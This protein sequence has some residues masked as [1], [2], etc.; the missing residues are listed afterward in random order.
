MANLY[1]D[2][3][4]V[5]CDPKGLAAVRKFVCQNKV[6]GIWEHNW[7]WCTPATKALLKAFLAGYNAGLRKDE[8]LATDCFGM[9]SR[10]PQRL[11]K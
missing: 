3:V 1:G 9:L 2:F 11:T 8:P 6:K 5:D 7:F 10:T 4:V